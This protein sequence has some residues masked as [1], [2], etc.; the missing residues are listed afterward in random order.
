MSSHAHAPGCAHTP[1]QAELGDKSKAHLIKNRAAG[2]GQVFEAVDGRLQVVLDLPFLPPVGAA[3][4]DNLR[5]GLDFEHKYYAVHHVVFPDTMKLPAF[6][7]KEGVSWIFHRGTPQLALRNA[8]AVPV[9]VHIEGLF[10]QLQV[11]EKPVYV[12]FAR[13]RQ[14]CVPALVRA[15][16]YCMPASLASP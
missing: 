2:S 3:Q 16:S 8:S 15:L 6:A 5:R 10:V 9:G 13:S 11:G 14:M 12:E 1:S 7:D 4:Y